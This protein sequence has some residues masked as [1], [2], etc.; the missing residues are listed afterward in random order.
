MAD[1]KLS[2]LTGIPE[3][4]QWERPRFNHRFTIEHFGV[5][6]PEQ[7]WRMADLGALAS[8]NIYYVHEPGDAYWKNKLGHERASQMSRLGTLARHNVTTALHTDR[9]TSTKRLGTGAPRPKKSTSR[10]GRFGA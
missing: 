4:L 9:N 5:S 1:T 2:R 3:K 10:V 8:V 7:V 6:T